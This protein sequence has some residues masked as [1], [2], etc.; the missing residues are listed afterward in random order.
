[1]RSIVIRDAQIVYFTKRAHETRG[2]LL[3]VN[4]QYGG[5]YRPTYHHVDYM[6]FGWC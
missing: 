2:G 3:N 1:V 5:Q 4:T 6:A